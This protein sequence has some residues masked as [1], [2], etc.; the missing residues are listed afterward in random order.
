[1][2]SNTRALRR[3]SDAASGRRPLAV[4]TAVAG[5]VLALTLTGGIASTAAAA[6]A[7]E[8]LGRYSDRAALTIAEGTDA[9]ETAEALGADVAEA[10][11]DLGETP[12][13]VDTAEV[14]ANLDALEE[15]MRMPDIVVA[16]LAV[17]TE[18]EIAAVQDE[19]A[20]LKKA[21]TVAK[22]KKA[23]AEAKR[24]AEE[25]AAKERAAAAA[26]ALAEG[27]TVAGAKATAQRL[28]SSQYGWGSGEFSCLVSLWNKESG[29]N[30][31]AYNP[32]GATGIPQALPGSKMASAGSDW[33]T[34]AATQVAWGLGYISS[35]YGTPCSAW[36]HSQAMNWY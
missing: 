27:N 8:P 4:L 33:Q 7:T 6:A 22:E 14:K 1:M 24:A 10:D 23:A 13:T 18:A 20:A 26:A 34:N 5:A 19:T 30:Y 21:F 17:D 31:Q 25:K 9:L 12:T 32:S 36:A 15:R 28:A 3:A 16:A 35:V 11:L 2:H 29:W